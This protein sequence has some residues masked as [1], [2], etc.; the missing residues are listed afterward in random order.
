MISHLL[1]SFHCCE[2]QGVIHVGETVGN[3]SGWVPWRNSWASPGRKKKQS[4]PGHPIPA[5]PMRRGLT[6]SRNWT[7]FFCTWGINRAV[8]TG[9]TGT[10]TPCGG[11]GRCVWSP[12]Q[13]SAAVGREEWRPP[14]ISWNTDDRVTPSSNKG[15]GR[16]KLKGTKWE[17]TQTYG[18]MKNTEQEGRRGH[19]GDRRGSLARAG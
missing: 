5:K 19:E 8:P 1:S 9:R 2:D 12:G 13:G 7:R 11:K 18:R 14:P 15:S 3:Q 16:D 4:H 10:L 6:N 17:P